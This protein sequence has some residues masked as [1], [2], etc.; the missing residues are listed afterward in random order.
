M[1]LTLRHT[2]P[3]LA[4]TALLIVG[5]AAAAQATGHSIIGGRHNDT[6]ARTTIHRNTSGPVLSLVTHGSAAPLVVSSDTKVARLNADKLDGLSASSLQ[7]RVVRYTLPANTGQRGLTVSFPGLAAG[8]YTANMSIAIVTTKDADIP[9]GSFCGF[10]DA[11]GR[12][13]TPLTNGT[14]FGDSDSRTFNASGVIDSRKLAGLFCT[15]SNGTMEIVAS[16]VTFTRVDGVTSRDSAVI[17][18]P[19]ALAP[20]L[21]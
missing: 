11:D 20:Q 8:T 5:S 16:E 3:V 10:F 15:T 17:E 18:Q 7:T 21:R 14:D 2:V 19:A 12:L 1:K 9:V 13:I 4:A 6:S